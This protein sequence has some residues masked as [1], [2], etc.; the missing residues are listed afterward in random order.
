MIG[1]QVTYGDQLGAIQLMDC[2]H[3]FIDSFVNFQ[4]E[5]FRLILNFGIA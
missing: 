5:N 4:S 1:H 3:T 2:D